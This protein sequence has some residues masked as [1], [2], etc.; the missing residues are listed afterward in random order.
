[1]AG[2]LRRRRAVAAFAALT[3]TVLTAAACSSTANT[4]AS[5]GTGGAAG[6]PLG[7]VGTTADLIDISKVCGSK[8]I[9]VALADGFGG[10]SWRKVTRAEFEAEA[11]KC[12]NITQVLYTDGQNNPQ[13]AIS[14]INGLV[15]QGVDVIVVFADAGQAILPALRKATQAGVSVVPEIADPGGTPGKDYVDFVAEDVVSYG[16][17]LAEWTVKAMK[18]KGNLVML[19][20]IAGNGYSNNVFK[21]VQNVVAKNSGITLL[22]QNEPVATNWDPGE[23]QKVVAGLLTKYGQIDGIVSDYGGGSVGGIRAFQAANRPIPPWSANDSNEFACLWMQYKGSNPNYQIATISSR[24][25]MSRVALRKGVAHAQGVAD[26]EPSILKL[27]L[28]E[29]SIAGG[30]LAPKCDKALPP[31]AILSS[32]LSRDDLSKLFT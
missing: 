13:K 10:N 24:N 28:F 9:K 32:T 1:M 8:Q 19:G 4:P 26:P 31:D 18:G 2:D 14:D 11:K 20:G 3:A 15:A 21:G 23:T 22:N 30:E 16:E 17:S 27:P 25:W 6:G 12:P 29:D 5:S 7:Q